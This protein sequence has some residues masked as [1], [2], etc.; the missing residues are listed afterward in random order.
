MLQTRQMPRALCEVATV[1]LPMRSSGPGGWGATSL[2]GYS[3][4]VPG[5]LLQVSSLPAAPCQ[6]QA[7]RAR[8]ARVSP[9]LLISLAPRST[10]PV[11]AALDFARRRAGR[12]VSCRVQT[13]P[14]R[15]R[16]C[17]EPR[18]AP[19]RHAP[20][21]FHTQGAPERDGKYLPRVV[22]QLESQPPGVSARARAG[23]GEKLV[24]GKKNQT[25]KAS[26]AICNRGELAP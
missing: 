5:S 3:S 10:S 16:S 4:H 2:Q 18:A 20:T 11:R 24:G 6:A 9:P 21:G 17:P 12:A 15:A 7:R 8:T 13:S 19:R 23:E 25:P 22:S 14:C 26:E 1:S